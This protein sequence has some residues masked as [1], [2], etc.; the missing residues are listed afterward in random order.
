MRLCLS[1]K[2]GN[3]PMRYV[4]IGGSGLRASV[5]SLGC[6]RISDMDLKGISELVDQALELGI[7]LFDHADIYGGGKS[8]E[9]F[10]RA[11]GMNPEIRG[12]ILIQSKCGI[13]KGYY[14]L[15]AKHILESVD[16][17][18]MRLGTEYLDILILHRPDTL[19]E[20][21]EI[22]AAFERLEMSG[23]VRFF[24]VSNMNPMQIELLSKYLKQKLIINQLQFSVAHTGIIDS[25]LNVNMANAP[26]IDRDGSVLEYCRL[27]NIT[28][29]AWSP[30][31][32]G[33]FE[34]TFIGNEKYAGLNRAL[35][36]IAKEKGVTSAAVAVAWI[37]R[38][39][40]NMQA[41]VGTTKKGRIAEIAK[42]AD[43]E[44]SR[45]EWYEIY[46]SAGNK[47]P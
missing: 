39:P 1:M 33:F 46:C 40:A 29:Q 21:E 4:N 8:E 9:K 14:D 37:L 31:Q 44:L 6:M 24:G 10:A 12:K 23:K 25:G 19:M 15:S 34:G 42:A 30:L 28:I 36:R 18:L 17:I 13:C 43:I 35:D 20:P 7:N 41:V 38:H 5:I 26:G 11:I 27:K 47:L 2:K 22:A 32:Y 45:A 16:N 3:R